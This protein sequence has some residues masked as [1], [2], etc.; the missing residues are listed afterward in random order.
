MTRHLP[1]SLRAFGMLILVPWRL[2]PGRTAT[3]WIGE[4]LGQVA[5]VLDSFMLAM[6]AGAV[7]NG[8]ATD[9]VRVALAL[10]VVTGS[11]LLLGAIGLRS[12]LRL[13]EV[14]GAELETRLCTI[15]MSPGS[16]E[17]LERPATS[18]RIELIRGATQ[19]ATYYVAL[20]PNL[21]GT[22]VVFAG[23]LALLSSVTPLAL[24]LAPAAAPRAFVT[25]RSSKS[26]TE[27]RERASAYVRRQRHLLT[28]ATGSAG[29]TELRAFGAGDGILGE[30]GRVAAASERTMVLA[31]ARRARARIAAQAFYL[32]VLV[33]VLASVL[34]PAFAGTADAAEVVLVITL[35]T[36]LA[37]SVEELGFRVSLGLGAARIWA[38]F[39]SL[40]DDVRG[41]SGREAMASMRVAPPEVLRE[42]LHLRGVS[43]LY[44]GASSPA[45]T[46]LNLF[47]PAGS[48]VALVG[49][50]GA[51]KTTLVKLL[52]GLYE[53]STGSIEVDGIGLKE[54]AHDAW[55]SRVGGAFQDFVRPEFLF[56]EAVG[57]G[58]VSSMLDEAAIH[59]ALSNAG[60]EALS[61]RLPSGLGTQL[62]SRWP[63]GVDL[64]GGEWQKVA[65]ARGDMR[66]SLLLHVLDEPTAALD[67][68]SEHELFRYLAEAGNDRGSG[69]V[70]VLVSHRFATV[71]AADLIVVLDD[72]RIVETGTHSELMRENAVYARMYMSQAE[73]FQ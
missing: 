35:G 8:D 66:E 10:A 67:A 62:G 40:N 15:T 41:M 34:R 31:L 28:V 72:G 53:P 59:R 11:T 65:L 29:G 27:A 30:H 69:R 14:V 58:D 18:D 49:P 25:L 2:A 52:L 64:S 6:L 61:D 43:F 22:L 44:P 23:A 60:A 70:T 32:A 12:R 48:T 56:R 57:I 47:M 1:E 20:G 24:L 37:G 26:I 17:H 7:T 36:A 16:L 51:G 4:G 45:V 42:G 71:R 13:G 39:V 33:A 5:V 50:N 3:I 73:A 54:L 46:D 21:V 38:R 63:D 19:D 9:A 55:R 68:Y